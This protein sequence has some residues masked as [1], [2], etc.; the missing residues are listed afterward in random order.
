MTIQNK[1]QKLEVQI[2]H[3]KVKFEESRTLD[4]EFQTHEEQALSYLEEAL[5]EQK[6]RTTV[7][8]AEFSH[9]RDLAYTRNNIS[10]FIQGQNI[11]RPAPNPLL[12]AVSDNC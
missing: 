4:P 10:A 8:S 6:R 12:R 5:E 1:I 11:G 9:I 3:Q 7:F 2:E